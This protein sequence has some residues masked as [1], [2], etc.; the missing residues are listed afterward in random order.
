MDPPAQVFLDRLELLRQA[1]LPADGDSVY[2]MKK[3]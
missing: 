3:K 2:A 1:D